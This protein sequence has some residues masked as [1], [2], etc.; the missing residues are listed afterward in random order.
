MGIA[1]HPQTR[2]IIRAA[3]DAQYGEGTSEMVDA[4][5]CGTESQRDIGVRLDVTQQAISSRVRKAKTYT[6]MLLRSAGIVNG[7]MS[8]QISS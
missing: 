7:A 6:R 4:Y 2:A 1:L 5:E 8:C 3:V